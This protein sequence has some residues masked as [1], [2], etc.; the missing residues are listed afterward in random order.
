M[1]IS[2]RQFLY[3]AAADHEAPGRPPLRGVFNQ[4]NAGATSSRKPAAA[5]QPQADK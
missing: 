1:K 3:Q 2:R 5:S 4:I